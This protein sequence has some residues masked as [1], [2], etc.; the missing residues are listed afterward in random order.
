MNQIKQISGRIEVFDLLRG[1]FIFMILIDHAGR[2][3]GFWELFTGRGG[4]WVSAAEGFFFIS[5]I[6]IGLIRGHKMLSEPIKQVFKRCWSRALQLYVWSVGLTLLFSVLALIFHTNP[7]VK[8]GTFLGEVGSYNFFK[9][10]LLLTFTYGW[11]DFLVYYC[12]YLF[13]SPFA[14]YLMRKKIWWLVLAVSTFIWAQP[15]G[16]YGNFQ[17][18]FFGGAIIGYHYYSIMDYL[19]KLSSKTKQVAASSIYTLSAIT[20]ALS[21]F[22]SSIVREYGKDP[23][24]SLHS[25]R[26]VAITT[27]NPLFAKTSLPILRV[28]LFMLW[29]TALYLIFKKYEPW[30]KQKLGWLLLPFG[31]NSLYAYIMHAIILFVLNLIIPMGQH[32]IINIVISTSFFMLIWYLTKNK[33][34]FKFVPR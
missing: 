3:F 20:L 34:L 28:L 4:Q 15:Y 12:V 21:V 29:F 24:S 11:A 16:I 31:Q 30:I 14:I 23:S 1:Y 26:E 7:G 9:D 10:T 25:L 27:I 32:W 18:L 2:F 22:F 19:S 17:L 13:F 5:G 8:A 33:F 6:M